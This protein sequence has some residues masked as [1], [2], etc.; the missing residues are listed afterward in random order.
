MRRKLLALALLVAVGV[1]ALA[2]SIGG[3]GASQTAA[4]EYLT[5]DAVVG[6]V[7]QDVAATGSLAA[8]TTYGL[9]FGSA[10]YLIVESVESPASDW[11][12]PSS[13][14]P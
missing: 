5:S 12:W 4:T 14:R 2:M 9:T 11:T 8:T 10:P 1:V 3:V 13:R 7:T 6:D